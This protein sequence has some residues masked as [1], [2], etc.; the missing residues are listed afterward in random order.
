[1]VEMKVYTATAFF[2][3]VVAEAGEVAGRLLQ[4]PYHFGTREH[5]ARDCAEGIWQWKESELGRKE[6]VA[7]WHGGRVVDYYHGPEFG[8]ASDQV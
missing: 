5:V 1:M 6:S 4:Y 7:L 8:W 3:D 2:P